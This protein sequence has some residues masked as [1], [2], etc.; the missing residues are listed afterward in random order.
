MWCVT[1]FRNTLHASQIKQSQQKMFYGFRERGFS[2]LYLLVF[3]WG[4]DPK[5]VAD[6]L[7][8]EIYIRY[9][10]KGVLY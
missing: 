5:M 7:Y 8:D 1:E 9:H 10:M 6:L 2:I 4:F 3:G